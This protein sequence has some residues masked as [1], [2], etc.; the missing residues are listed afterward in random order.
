MAGT[1]DECGVPGYGPSD[2]EA[3]GSNCDE[4]T[5]ETDLIDFEEERDENPDETVLD[6]DS[7][8][9]TG[10]GDSNEKDQDKSA[11]KDNGKKFSGGKKQPFIA[12]NQGKVGMCSHDSVAHGSAGLQSEKCH[13][14]PPSAPAPR[15]KTA[16]G[17]FVGGGALDFPAQYHTIR[18]ARRRAANT[19]TL[20]G[21]GDYARSADLHQERDM[22]FLIEGDGRGFAV[23]NF[24]RTDVGRNISISATADFACL[25]CGRAHSYKD[26][27]STGKPLVAVLSD[28]SFPPMLPSGRGDCVMVIRVE[29]GLLSEIEN[30]FFDYVFG[31]GA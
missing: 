17:A 11:E 5:M 2:N 21:V 12:E 24:H 8:D 25:S 26:S 6:G 3:S 30:T 18:A 31:G 13:K 27:V 10:P 15:D 20:G 14:T 23:S 4:E 9:E 19:A 29:D 22:G 16:S 7:D 1:P 28:Q